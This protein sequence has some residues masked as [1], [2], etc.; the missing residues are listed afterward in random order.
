MQLLLVL[1]ADHVEY[2]VCFSG[3]GGFHSHLSGRNAV[4][5]HDPRLFAVNLGKSKMGLYPSCTILLFSNFRP[6]M[7][8][9]NAPEL[10]EYILK[11]GPFRVFTLTT[12]MPM[13]E[14]LQMHTVT[15][16]DIA[17]QR[18]GI[19]LMKYSAFKTEI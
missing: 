3:I 1:N 15:K 18:S 19:M 12:V 5:M 8:L 7:H 16:P 9:F 10:C 6:Y 17:G 4:F 14:R 13:I 2:N 11:H